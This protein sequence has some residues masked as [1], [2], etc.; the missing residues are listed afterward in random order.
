MLSDTIVAPS[1]PPGESALAVVRL[2]GPLC[3]ELAT[4]VF[5]KTP[6]PRLATYGVYK[7]LTGTN[8]DR[9]V[10]V[11]Y[12]QH[13]SYTGETMLEISCH[14]NGMIVDTIVSDCVARG[15]RIAEAGEFTKRAFLN[16]KMDLS[17]AEAV[18]DMIHAKSTLALKAAEKQLSGD[19]KHRVETLKNNLLQSI[20]HVEVYNDFPDEDL[21]ESADNKSLTLMDD[22]LQD[23][24][25]LARSHRHYATV[26]DGIRT[27][28]LGAPNAGKSSLL[29]A[30]LGHERALVSHTPGTTRDFLMEYV[31]VGQHTL[32]IV[33]TAGLRTDADALE[34]LGIERTLEQARLADCFIVV[35]DVSA[36]TPQFNEWVQALLTPKNTLVL[37]NKID[38]DEQATTWR[39]FMPTATHHRLSLKTGEGV[40]ALPAI[41][42][43]WLEQ[44]NIADTEEGIK[45]NLR[46]LQA[47]TAAAEH[48][49][50]ARQKLIAQ[51]QMELISL[52]IEQALTH[53]NCIL[54]N[55]D[56]EAMLDI[57]FSQFCIGK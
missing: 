29:N 50:G 18:A 2:S 49:Q 46:H 42:E 16:G 32:R 20:A 10:F 56:N 23:L 8:V 35:V 7:N 44:Q 25:A 54:G 52:D 28:I 13:A 21:P 4:T 36:P 27:V 19:L 30:L 37:E 9:V 48:I 12:P 45:I 22:V 41:L 55:Y 57:V 40:D 51:Q 47:L 6:Q 43:R 34:Q 3:L 33:D 15:C 17:Q 1:T 38:L 5:Q 11:Y 24:D 31:R 14:G 26:R 39:N 53:L